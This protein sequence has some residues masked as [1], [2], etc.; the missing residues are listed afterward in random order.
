MYLENTIF[1]TSNDPEQEENDSSEENEP[2]ELPEP[3][4]GEYITKG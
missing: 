2:I 4:E 3:D 1:N